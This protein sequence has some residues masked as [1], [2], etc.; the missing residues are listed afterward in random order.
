MSEDLTRL[1][2]IFAAAADDDP[3]RHTLATPDGRCPDPEQVFDA[4]HGDLAP[5]A[6]A[7]LTDHVARCPACAEAWR[8]AL[9]LEPRETTAE[10]IPLFPRG[11][12]RPPS[13]S[14]L[15]PEPVDEPVPEGGWLRRTAG[16][17]VGAVAVV[18]VLVTLAILPTYLDRPGKAFDDDAPRLTTTADA[19]TIARGAPVP[20]AWSGAPPDT[21]YDVIV[22]DEARAVVASATALAEP[23]WTLPGP[24]TAAL[25]PGSRLSWRV[26]A[27]TP[28][29]T[30]LASPTWTLI[31]AE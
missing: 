19:R 10:V 24:L 4:A 1:R 14:E 7:H 3:L 21:V 5:D 26:D 12:P 17:A 15:E 27:R 23:S 16:F 30:A 31:L 6:V 25:E 8:L 18:A 20:L 9:E 29:G 28:D 22:T 13:R 11:A 2:E